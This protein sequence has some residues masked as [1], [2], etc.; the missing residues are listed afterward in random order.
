M[1]GIC[2][3]KKI[4]IS[5]SEDTYERLKQYAWENHKNV[6]QAI[7]DWIWTEKVKNEQI[8][9]QQTLQDL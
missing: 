1:K 5:I 7:T 9:G 3:K 4:C 8:R 2:M 6:S